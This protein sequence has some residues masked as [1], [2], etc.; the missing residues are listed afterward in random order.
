MQMTIEAND[1]LLR[2][3]HGYS[4]ILGAEPA[5]TLDASSSRARVLVAGGE[6]DEAEEVY[7]ELLPAY[8]HVQDPSASLMSQAAYSLASVL[9]Q[10]G[11]LDRAEETYRRVLTGL[12]S[13]KRLNE[14][15]EFFLLALP[16][17]RT[18]RSFEYVLLLTSIRRLI[19]AY[20]SAGRSAEAEKM[21]IVCLEEHGLTS[22]SGGSLCLATLVAIGELYQKQGQLAEAARLFLRAL[23]GYERTPANYQNEIANT[24][25]NLANFYVF[26]DKLEEAG[27][28]VLK[29]I[30]GYTNTL[31]ADHHYS[32]DA[33]SNLANIWT[34]KRRNRKQR[35]RI[36]KCSKAKKGPWAPNTAK[37]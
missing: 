10:L 30:Q 25:H 13:M 35:R 37:R 34:S 1:L 22:L 16:V 7:L 32:L 31:G 6:L 15:G 5:V 17:Q 12:E 33:L 28:M 4:E 8:E 18:E 36:C 29:A 3:S 14:A 26:Q 19:L 20:L 23:D 11:K 27:T 2:A 9:Q 24:V 21:A